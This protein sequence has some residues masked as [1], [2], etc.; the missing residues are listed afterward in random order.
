[1]RLTLSLLFMAT[2]LAAPLAVLAN[3][4][5]EQEARSQTAASRIGTEFLWPDDYRIAN[6]ETALR[7]LTEA[8]NATGVN[9][10]RTSV[11]TPASGPERITYY[12]LLARDHSALFDEFS[13]AEGRWPSRGESRTGAATV[14]TARAGQPSIIGVPVVFGGGYDLTIAPLGHAFDTLPVAGRYVVE[15]HDPATVDRF[16]DLIHRLVV[17]SGVPDLTV[18]DFTAGRSHSTLPDNALPGGSRLNVLAYILTGLAALIIAFLLLREGKRIGV[19]RL[20]GHSPAR[21][22]YRVVGRLQLV[23]VLLGMLACVAVAF[24]V[25]G[26]GTAL[27]TTLAPA[28]IGVAVTGFAAITIVGLIIIDR[29]RVADLIK[30][31]LQ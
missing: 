29:V 1:V 30:G 15:T 5:F 27:A 25:P 10:L 16:L 20:L 12:L 9:V 4:I 3:T 28:L 31:R 23:S 13:L 14:S 21:I 19:L 22:W 17:D 8:A 24:L 18:G 11:N 6:P 7:I 2:L 26:G